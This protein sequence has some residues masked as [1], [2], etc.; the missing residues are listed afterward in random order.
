MDRRVHPYCDEDA[1]II[2]A[3]LA[4][5]CQ[6]TNSGRDALI[7]ARAVQLYGQGYNTVAKLAAALGSH[8]LH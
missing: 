2:V 5:F 6:S 3:A 4:L 8:A 1:K 7:I